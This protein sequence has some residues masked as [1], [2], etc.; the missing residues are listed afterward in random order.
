MVKEVGPMTVRASRDGDVWIL[1][2]TED[3]F[4]GVATYA[5][6]DS[7][8]AEHLEDHHGAAHVAQ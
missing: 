8:A 2:C 7:A 6:V 5:E 3:G 4:I 1:E